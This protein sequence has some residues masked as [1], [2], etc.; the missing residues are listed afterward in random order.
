MIFDV[1]TLS[2]EM[3]LPALS[4]GMTHRALQEGIIQVHT[5]NLRA[6]SGNKYGSVDDAPY[7][8][9]AGMI[10][11]IEPVVHAF[12]AVAAKHGQGHR[13][14]FSPAGTPLTQAKVRTL[15]SLPHLVLLCGRYEGIDERISY[16][17]DEEIS[18]GDFI[19]SGGEWAALT[20]IDAVTRL[21]PGVL[22]NQESMQEESFE[23]SQLEYPQYTRPPM[24]NGLAVPKVL[25]SGDHKKIAQWR[26][27]QALLR[28]K[29]RRPDLL[30]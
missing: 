27:E 24:F 12:D 16:Y 23:Q 5:T 17:V 26:K 6:Y 30:K 1:I 25:L 15:T 13:I 22:H 9:G 19:I 29:A 18:L 3:I 4:F 11:R 14:L 10:V 28:T 8:G 2:P 7:G 21:L 20:L